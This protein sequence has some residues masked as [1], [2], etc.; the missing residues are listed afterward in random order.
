MNETLT[1]RCFVFVK[2][3]HF[4]RASEVM[5]YFD[6]A[7][8]S[9]GSAIFYRAVDE[10]PKEIAGAHYG[11]HKG[12]IKQGVDI[13]QVLV[14]QLTG[15]PVSL[16]VYEGKPGLTKKIID[17]VGHRDPAIARPQRFIKENGESVET[18]RGKFSDPE[19][20]EARALAGKYATMNVMH[21]AD[22]IIST[23]RELKVWTQFL[24]EYSRWPEGEAL[25]LNLLGGLE[26][27]FRELDALL[28]RYSPLLLV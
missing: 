4:S 17:L 11:L 14:E 23:L 6:S 25:V 16:A 22:S 2:P 10:V 13:H 15:K 8:Q 3:E 24:K 21:R 20:T 26:F 19:E 28:E 7:L 1:E 27:P 12:K 5:D 9:Y 18:I